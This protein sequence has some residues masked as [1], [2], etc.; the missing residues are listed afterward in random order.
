M[1]DL[2]K[3]GHIMLKNKKTNLRSK[4][5]AYR[6]ISFSCRQVNASPVIKGHSCNSCHG[7][8]NLVKVKITRREFCKLDDHIDGKT[9][10]AKS[11]TRRCKRCGIIFTEEF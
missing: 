11:H 4:L 6:C 7:K 8:D 1:I 2:N 3:E 10:S 5:I 9:I